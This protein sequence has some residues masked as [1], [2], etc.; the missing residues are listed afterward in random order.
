MVRCPV[1]LL[2]KTVIVCFLSELLPLL[3]ITDRY[4][5][6]ANASRWIRFNK[7]VGKHDVDLCLDWIGHCL[8]PFIFLIG[9]VTLSGKNTPHPCYDLTEP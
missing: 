8:G 3:F 7:H 4:C 9:C 1:L 2:V 5:F 6:A